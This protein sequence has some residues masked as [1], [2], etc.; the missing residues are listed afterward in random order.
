M[1]VVEDAV[2]ALE[3]GQPVVLPTDTVYGLCVR[4]DDERAAEL[5]YELKQRPSSDPIAIL[6]AELEGIFAA[7]PEL[8]DPAR[9]VCSALLPGP[10]TL[11]LPNPARH[12]PSLTGSRPDTI[13]VRVPAF[14][15]D[16]RS[17]VERVGVVAATSANRHGGPDPRAV[18]EVPPEIRDRCGSVV[19]AGPLPGTPSTVLDLT[20][21]EP[22]VIREGAVAAADALALARQAAGT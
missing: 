22:L 20:E 8:G 17:V 2:A 1:G 18:D 9:A 11:V 5:L 21:P 6:A 16:G 3:G 12:Y 4:P 10:Y 7:I 14:S 19:D 13:G 15:G